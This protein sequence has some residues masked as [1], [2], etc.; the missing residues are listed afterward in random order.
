MRVWIDATQ[1][2]SRVRIFGMTLVERQLRMVAEGERKARALFSAV[3]NVGID[4]ARRKLEALAASHGRPTEVSIEL[5]AGD[6]DPDWIPSELLTQLPIRWVR[7]PGTTRERLQRELR[8]AGGESV[9]AF[10]GDTV[11]DDR[12]IEHLAWNAAGSIAF[13][14][15]DGAASA[16]VV[17]LDEPLP[18]SPESDATILEIARDAVRAG[19]IKQVQPD[20][21]ENYIKKL[22]RD[23]APFAFQIG[24][25]TTR[26][27]VERFLF[28]SNY[29]G[30]TDFMT[31]WVYPPLV[32]R[33]LQ[34]LTQRRAKPNTVTFVGMVSCFAAVPLFATGMWVPGLAL[35]YV[36]S[37]L[38]SVDGKLAR[39]TYQ[40]SSQ[41]DVLDH[42]MD[43]VHPP[44]WYW[45]WGW[46]LSGGDVSSGVFQASMWMV[47]FYI[48]DR[49]LETLFTASTGKSI[50]GYRELDMR[51]RTFI[52]RRNVNLAVFTVALPL[53]LAIPAFYAIVAWQAA[54]AVFHLS[55]VIKFWNDADGKRSQSQN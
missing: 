8:K 33:I 5:P 55:R 48:F 40:S 14:H 21:V 27:R 26:D 34:V 39:L 19:A 17:R 28:D 13:I 10:A 4:G 23:L 24:D 9:L 54:S 31:K 3:Q 22:R 45:A 16:A 32:W 6:P 47:V 53:G 15:D 1:P 7:E 37:V 43:I 35:A 44:F 42:G 20:D 12:V 51:V 11:I 30:S 38:D 18:D 36:M 49:V 29:K 2:G 52:S 50:H 41:G 46:A 25:D